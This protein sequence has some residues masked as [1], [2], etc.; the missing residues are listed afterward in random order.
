MANFQQNIKNFIPFKCI[1]KTMQV[2]VEETWRETVTRYFDF[3]QE[4]LKQLNIV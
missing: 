1:K 4:H 3:F 2:K